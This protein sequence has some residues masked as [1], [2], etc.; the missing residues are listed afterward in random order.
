[1]QNLLK[2]HPHGMGMADIMATKMLVDFAYL[3]AF[4]LYN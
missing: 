2:G 1:M 3:M 4:A